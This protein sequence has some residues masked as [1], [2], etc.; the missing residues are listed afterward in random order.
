MFQPTL[1]KNNMFFKIFAKYVFV[2]EQYM[3]HI[4]GQYKDIVLVL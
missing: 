2:H 4:C 3:D 1:S